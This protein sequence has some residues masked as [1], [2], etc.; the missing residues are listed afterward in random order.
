M[1]K[2]LLI[3]FLSLTTACF[4]QEKINEKYSYKA[5]PYHR[6]S[7]KSIPAKEFNNTIIVGSCFYQE[8]TEGDKTIVKDIFPN[9]MTGVIFKQ[10]NLD[11]V[12]VPI[13]NTVQSGTHKKIKFQNDLENWILN[14][15]ETPKEPIN[16]EQRLEANVSVDPKDIPAKKWTKEERD[17]FESNFNNANIQSVQ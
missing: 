2:K 13:G 4:A 17:A 10:C 16:K 6:V 14:K 11:N 5:F 1:M 7:F 15:D 3:A 8:W 9:G 12:L